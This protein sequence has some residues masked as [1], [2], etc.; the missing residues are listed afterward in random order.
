MSKLLPGWTEN[1][2]KNY[3]YSSIRRLK[4]NPIFDLIKE[5]Y[6]VKSLTFSELPLKAFLIEQ[7]MSKF[8]R[9][10]QKICEF[11][12]DPSLMKDPF[13]NFLLGVLLEHKSL[14]I[15]SE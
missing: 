6:V 9:L 11:L 5:I 12:L 13:H 4:S 2:I 14:K 7:E 3:F 1:S 8:N 15:P 10:S